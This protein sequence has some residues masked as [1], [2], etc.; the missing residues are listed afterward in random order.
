MKQLLSTT[1]LIIAVLMTSCTNSVEK[2]LD[3]VWEA[4]WTETDEDGDEW[5]YYETINLNADTHEFQQLVRQ[6]IDFNGEMLD[7]GSYSIKGTWNANEDSIELIYDEKD[8]KLDYSTNA[9]M[10]GGGYDAVI[11]EIMEGAQNYILNSYSKTKFSIPFDNG[12]ECVYHK[13][14]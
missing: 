4:M 6:S 13:K 5:Q 1:L 7:M 10:V 12:D 8:I 11:S 2:T 14:L 3:G 9:L